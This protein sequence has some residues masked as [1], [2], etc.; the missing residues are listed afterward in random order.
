MEIQMI[1]FSFLIPFL[2]LLL[3]LIKN[4]IGRKKSCNPPPGPQ[5]LPLI[6]NILQ[7]AGQEPHRRL[8]E[9]A[10]TYGPIMHIQLGQVR[11]A[12]I[13]SAETAKQVLKIQE[14]YFLGRPSLLAADVMLYNRTDISFA[15]YGDYWKQMKKIAILE[16]FSAKRVQSFKVIFD[17]EITSFVSFLDWNSGSPVNLSRKLRS[18]GNSMIAVASIGKKFDQQEEFLGVVDNAIRAAG[19]FSV[20]D[21]FPSAK[22]LQ[23]FSKTSSTL[24]TAHRQVDDILEEIISEHRAEKAAAG[25]KSEADNLLDVLLEIQEQ[26][27]LQLPVT[28]DNIKA[29][30]L[31]IFAGASDTTVGTAEWA[32]AE[33][34]K[35]PSTMQKAQEEVRRVFDQ[36]GSF[37]NDEQKYLK[38]VVKETLRLHPPVALIPRECSENF[39]IGGYDIEPKT[40]V[41]VNAWAIGRDPDSW[42]D[43]DRFYPERFLDNSIDYK[44]THFQ[45]IPFG[46]GKR[47]CPGIV[48]TQ[49]IIEPILARLLYHFDWELPDGAEPE[50]LAMDDVFGLVVKRQADLFLIPTSFRPN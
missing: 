14:S 40:K 4:L 24:H 29:L 20:A 12:V 22:L 10:K 8:T 38:L 27:N 15:P 25:A 7:L 1:H 44:G 42:K 37:M 45:L 9:L 11:V 19:G 13:S 47:I 3:K 31:D 33:M 50:S 49:A 6:G 34:M 41:L 35:N 21:A 5:G 18:L 26:E 30:I 43:P 2:L 23:M 36:N 48:M 39:Q 32:L 17:E 46:A 16:L 28:T